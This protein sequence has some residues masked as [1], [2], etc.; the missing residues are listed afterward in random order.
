MVYNFNEIINGFCENRKIRSIPLY[1]FN[2]IKNLNSTKLLSEKQ[3]KFLKV[4]LSKQMI[5]IGEKNI[6]MQRFQ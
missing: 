6:L 3:K 5:K 2:N 1:L 4:I